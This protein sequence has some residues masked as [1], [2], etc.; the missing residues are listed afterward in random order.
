[1]IAALSIIAAACGDDGRG[2]S[3]TITPNSTAPATT[4][5]QPKVGGSIKMGM[6]SE[7]AGLDPV[8]TNGGGT[9]GT[10]EIAAIFDTIMRY[11]TIAREVRTPDSGVADAQR[12]RVGVGR[13]SCARA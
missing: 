12:R 6:F 7:T 9:T 8:V 3:D 5:P 11:D 13:S 1:M 4:V 2:E 10:T